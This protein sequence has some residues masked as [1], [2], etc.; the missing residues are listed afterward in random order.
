MPPPPE[1]RSSKA[2]FLSYASQDTAAAKQ[3]CDALRQTGVEVW[4]DQDE[5]RGGDA[6]D[7]NIRRQIRECALFMPVISASTQARPEG[8]F[9]LE[10]HLAE[11]RSL[12]IAKGRPFIVPVAI[13]ATAEGDAL[14]PDAF[15]AVQWTRLP[16]GQATTP[17]S[18]QVKRLL[19]GEDERRL[20]VPASAS[21]AGSAEPARSEDGPPPIPDYELIRMIGQGSYGDVWLARGVTGIYRAVKV[22]WRARFKDA[23][24]YEREFRGLK[25]FAAMSLGESIQMA[26]LHVGRNDA[27]GFFYYVMELADD[28]DRGRDIDPGRY[29]PLTLT[30]VRARDG[31][32]RVPAKDCL[33]YGV[34]LA[35]VLAGLHKRGLVHRDIKPSNVILV[36][37]VPKLADI[38]L[39]TPADET[40]TYVGT[41]GFVPPEGPG[42]AAAD[43]FAL[44]RLLYE[45]STGLDRTDFP[46]LPPDLEKL[47]DRRLL[48]SL[49]EIILKACDPVATSRYRDGAALLADLQRLQAGGPVRRRWLGPVVLGFSLAAAALAV[50]VWRPW[51]GQSLSP[52]AGPRISEETPPSEA[53]KLAQQAMK[54][55]EDPNSSREA[56]FLADELCQRALTLDPQD[57]EVWATASFTSQY[58]FS[59]NYDRS[60]ARWEKARSQ[61]SRANQLDPQSLHVALALTGS[62]NGQANVEERRTAARKL[63]ERAPGDP[64][65]LFHLLTVEGL[66]PDNDAAIQKLIGEM[67]A[68]PRTGWLPKALDVEVHRLRRGGRFAEAEAIVEEMFAWSGDLWLAYYDK[69]FLMT[70]GCRDLSEAEAYIEQIPARYR[71]EPAFAAEIAQYWIW[72]AKPDEA[73]KAL[74]LVVPDYLEQHFARVPKA[75]LTGWAHAIAGRTVA[76]QA[77]WRKAL[78][79]VDERLKADERNLYLL[80]RRAELLA[81]TG[82]GQEARAAWNLRVELG[83]ARMPPRAIGAEAEVFAAL[84][85]TEAAIA[86]IQRGWAQ[87]SE[88]GR[89][90][91]ILPDLRYHPAFAAIR[92]DERFQQILAEGAARMD[93]LK[94]EQVGGAKSAGAVSSPAATTTASTA[95]PLAEARTAPSA[96]NSAAKLDE[97]RQLTRWSNMDEVRLKTAEGMLQEVLKV[98][99]ENG[100]AWALR[101]KVDMF[102]L[103]RGYDRSNERRKAATEHIARAAVLAPQSFAVRHVQAQQHAL[104]FFSEETLNLFRTLVQEQPDNQELLE[105]LG[106][107]LGR[108]G[109][110]AEAAE[111]L[112]RADRRILAAEVLADAREPQPALRLLEEEITRSN[113]AAALVAKAHIQCFTLLDLAAAAKT[114]RQVRATDW[115]AEVVVGGKL[116]IALMRRDAQAIDGVLARVPRPMVPGMLFLIPSAYV[117]GYAHV[118]RAQPEAAAQE[119][120]RALREVRALLETSPRDSA[121]RG[122]EAVLLAK[123]GDPDAA[124]ALRLYTSYRPGFDPK[125]FDY[126]YVLALVAA[127]GREDEVL[128]LLADGLRQASHRDN[129]LDAVLR[130]SPEFDALR[131]NPRFQELLRNLKPEGAQPPAPDPASARARADDKSVAVLAFA[132]MSP[133]PDNAFFSDGVHEDVITQLAKIRDLRVISRTSVLAFRESKKP[134]KEIAGIL[135]VAH[136]LEGSVRR[137]GNRVR[138]TAQ[139]IDA[140]TDDHLWA[141][142]YDRNLDDIFAIQGE[143]AQKIAAA[144]KAALSPDEA[145]A[146]ADKPTENADAYDLYLRARGIV[147]TELESAGDWERRVTLLEKAVALDP[148]FA[149]A[150]AQLAAANAFLKFVD[151]Y[152]TG[153][154]RNNGEPALGRAKEA[155]TTAL[156]LAPD[157]PEVIG[158]YGTYLFYGF[159]DYAGATAQY[160]RRAGLQPN[161]STVFHDLAMLQRRQGRWADALENARRACQLDPGNIGFLRTLKFILS[162]A[163]RFS[164]ELEIQRRIATLQPDDLSE[165]LQ[166]AAMHVNARGSFREGEEFF[167]NLPREVFESPAGIDMRMH[168]ARANGD[169][170]EAIRLDRLQPYYD[171]SGVPRWNQALWAAHAHFVAGD[172]AG[173]VARLGEHPAEIRK[174]AEADP[175]KVPLQMLLAV[176]ERILGHPEEARRLARNAAALDAA[177][178]D[179]L[180]HGIWQA[181]LA[182][183]L[184]FTGDLDGAVALYRELLTKPSILGGAPG[185]RTEKFMVSPALHSDP[186]FKALLDDPKH[187]APLF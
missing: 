131:G 18:D 67:R 159:G 166:L 100:E 161:S 165:Q 77:E 136:I 124:K 38:G 70:R 172:K 58:L 74:S 72:R 109:R 31:R 32:V 167:R 78:S 114:L 28:V 85:D 35:R 82:Q 54:L 48:L 181:W 34:E 65:V 97:V 134:L 177:D 112:V 79:G 56:M 80:D 64:Q 145:K 52:S 10:W 87:E 37:G 16:G 26:L 113:S 115:L 76:A 40:M 149:Q 183:E 43:V 121:L 102:M 22:V 162:I 81:L 139:L 30:E 137:A 94:A 46:R 144:L 184:D 178:G 174:L 123:L 99:P 24:P 158:S 68:L 92:S 108:L 153:D 141:E 23:Q 157:D 163:R 98:E 42:S 8:Y 57:A 143:I 45:L 147:I 135:G 132:N 187:S 125:R 27:A 5:L 160:E 89:V 41:E 13:D 146:L 2:V 12:L 17:F 1:S 33:A 150:W 19:S 62:E 142:T 111:V 182:R 47:P 71:L 96:S 9:R 7:R 155:M 4:F 169:L 21:P 133:D 171:A 118:L 105:E 36:D 69:L 51:A 25:E 176:L 88:P 168:W 29:V 63:H 6:W 104:W 90:A 116:E 130:F 39:V 156:R 129:F 66:F 151:K 60:L 59:F 44:G 120:Q 127:G 180:S 101:G 14:V 107:T 84:K 73:L 122:W 117:G 83:V 91:V 86:A 110:N 185:L 179:S 15:L 75:Y 11:Q 61:A 164:E 152:R 3:I 126:W 49:N 106:M 173:A 148:N 140:A 55:L 175:R 128:E 20:R 154:T 186:R 170:E 119:W 138:I 53:R 95:T 93:K 103:Q 50:G